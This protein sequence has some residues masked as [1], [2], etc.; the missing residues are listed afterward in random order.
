MNAKLVRI[1]LED[2]EL[3]WKMQV[4]AFQGLY[5][6]YHDTETSPATEKVNNV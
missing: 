5:A 6:K 2:A 4:E 3:L 1:G